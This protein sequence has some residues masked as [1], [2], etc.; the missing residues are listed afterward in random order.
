ML[1]TETMLVTRLVGSNDDGRRGWED[2]CEAGLYFLITC[3]AGSSDSCGI[4]IAL[5][6]SCASVIKR[7]V[8]AVKGNNKRLIRALV[9]ARHSR[10]RNQSILLYHFTSELMRSIEHFSVGVEK[11]ISRLLWFCFTTFLYWPEKTY[12]ILSAK[13]LRSHKYKIIPA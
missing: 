4:S 2:L 8:F 1:A 6:P 11:I 10:Q 7:V 13:Q 5:S 9:C 12:V 3:K